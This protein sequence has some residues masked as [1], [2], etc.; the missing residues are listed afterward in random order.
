MHSDRSNF[1]IIVN[2]PACGQCQHAIGCGSAIRSLRKAFVEPPYGLGPL[3]DGAEVSFYVPDSQFRRA[4]VL[5]YGV[6]LV[7]GFLGVLVAQLGAHLMGVA[8]ESAPPVGFFSGVVIGFFALSRIGFSEVQMITG[9]KDASLNEARPVP[10]L[11]LVSRGYC[12]LC[13]EMQQALEG[14]KNLPPY[15]LAIVDV[16]SVPEL[17]EKYDELV[18]VLLSND[19]K[20]ICRYHI[21]LA[22]VRE[23]LECFE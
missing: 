4:A 12:H 13:T 5:A 6:P 20:E 16:D 1:A 18:P 9:A 23:Y 14:A 2:R 21:D 19:N 22:K 3:R 11:T 17:L 7:L 15:Q 8:V 10:T